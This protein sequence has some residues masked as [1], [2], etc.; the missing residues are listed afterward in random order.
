MRVMRRSRTAGAALLALATVGMLGVVP[1]HAAF[2]LMKITEIFSGTTAIPDAQFVELQMYSGGQNFVNGHALRVSDATGTL[3]TTVPMSNDVTNGAS[4]SSILLAT[5]DAASLFGV[6]PDFTM[7]AVL[8]RGGGK[9]CFDGIDCV[10]WGSYTGPAPGVGT[11]FHASDGLVLDSSVQR[12][13][14]RGNAT[15]L[16]AADDTD[17]SAAD[18]W[19]ASPKPRNNAGQ[20][21]TSDCDVVAAPS[22]ADIT[23]G[24]QL[25]VELSACPGVELSVATAEGTAETPDD[26]DAISRSIT[27]T[28]T[29]ETVLVQTHDDDLMEGDETL[30]LIVRDV[31]GAFLA[32]PD[33]DLTILD[34]APPVDGVPG[35]PLQV[36]VARGVRELTVTWQAPVTGDAVQGYRIYAGPEAGPRVPIATLVHTARTFTETGLSNHQTRSYVVAAFNSIGEGPQP[37]PVVGATYA[38]PTAPVSLVAEP[39]MLPGEVRLT[40]ATPV[41]DGGLPI[42]SFVIYE[43]SQLAPMLVRAGETPGHSTSVTLAGRTPVVEHRYELAAVTPVGEGPRSNRACTRPFPWLASL[44]CD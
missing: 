33:V 5:P 4:Q 40:W 42:S 17:V 25:S 22:M 44:V 39:G 38:L 28:E 37:P 20:S 3:I 1:A 6:T 14:D 34:V 11:P 12:R 24:A 41:D 18:L 31:R 35:A 23:E 26:V 7:P 2:H 15:L 43:A 9:L 8:P 36:A 21:F 32:T 13:I 19:F 30:R 27:F 10:A 29:L 16:D